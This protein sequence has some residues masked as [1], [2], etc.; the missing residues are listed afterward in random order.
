MLECDPLPPFYTI[1]QKYAKKKTSNAS[2]L[3]VLYL[4]LAIERRLKNILR[5]YTYV[6]IDEVVYNASKYSFQNRDM[7]YKRVPIVRLILVDPLKMISFP[8][9]YRMNFFLSSVYTVSH[10]FPISIEALS[11]NDLQIYVSGAYKKGFE[12]VTFWFGH[13]WRLI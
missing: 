3:L 9:I 10:R 7:K 1:Y 5:S 13:I 4:F 8:L 2:H 12:R 6:R 11:L